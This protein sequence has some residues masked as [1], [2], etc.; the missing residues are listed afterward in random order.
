MR[1]PIRERQQSLSMGIII[2]GAG[3][4]PA[5]MGVLITRARRTREEG[6]RAV[7]IPVGGTPAVGA[8][9]RVA[10]LCA[11]LCSLRLNHEFLTTKSAK[12]TEEE[13]GLLA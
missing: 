11:L 8:G 7:D 2:T 12:I 3:V 9:I 13:I 1:S 6:T 4:M 5:L 10:S